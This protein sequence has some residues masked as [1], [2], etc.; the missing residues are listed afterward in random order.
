MDNQ[1]SHQRHLPRTR[2]RRSAVENHG[3]LAVGMTP[4]EL[5]KVQKT[6]RKQDERKARN[7]L[8]FSWKFWMYVLAAGI[9]A[10]LLQNLDRL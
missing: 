2:R 1:R 6:I 4:Q 8:L 7:R 9:V 3:G 10:G 5:A